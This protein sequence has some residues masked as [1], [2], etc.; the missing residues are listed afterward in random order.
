MKMVLIMER[1]RPGKRAFAKDA[2]LRGDPAES[3]YGRQKKHD[4]D[5]GKMVEMWLRNQCG[6][7]LAEARK[8]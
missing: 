8:L 1:R 3:G 2:G 7:R 5:D 6:T 4:R